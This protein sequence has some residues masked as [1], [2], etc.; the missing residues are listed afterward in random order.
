MCNMIFLLFLST[1]PLARNSVFSALKL[2]DLANFTVFWADVEVQREAF[3]WML[4]AVVCSHSPSIVHCSL[5][6]LVLSPAKWKVAT[7]SVAAESYAGHRK[8][9]QL[10]PWKCST[11][12]G[13]FLGKWWRVTWG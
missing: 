10:I 5:T 4:N 7:S 1:W 2:G 3:L 11:W 8:V 9:T 13:S 6:L 12:K